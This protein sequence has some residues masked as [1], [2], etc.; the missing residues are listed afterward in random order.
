MAAATAA[1][2]SGAE[3]RRT[4]S[5]KLRITQ[6][7]PRAAGVASGS[8][9]G[10]VWRIPRGDCALCMDT[11]RA[12]ACV[13]CGHKCVCAAG[14]CGGKPCPVCRS[15]VTGMMKIFDWRAF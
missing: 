7:L 14:P 2:A 11:R 1:M 15:P 9:K 6:E 5:A 10:G 4:F 8:A 12:D 3:V 13:P